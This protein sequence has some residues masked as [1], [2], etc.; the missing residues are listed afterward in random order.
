[1]TSNLFQFRGL[2]NYNFKQQTDCCGTYLLCLML[3]VALTSLLVPF[4]GL[5]SGR[6][7]HN[8][9]LTPRTPPPPPPLQ[10]ELRH[11]H[12]VSSSAHVIF[13]DVA[14]TFHSQSD[15]QGSTSHPYSLQPRSIKTFRP[16]SND[17]FTRVR[18]RSA[19]FAE[20][21]RLDWD[22]ADMLGP[23]V[24]KREV[25]LELAKMANN[26]YVDP[27]DPEWYDLDPKWNNVC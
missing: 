21:E 6:S 3:P 27:S 7:N 20:S 1:M 4:L 13:S 2:C 23:D 15:T 22:E 12:A 10:F 14:S 24:E 16:P 18:K 5:F 26:A 11:L 9:G 8:G 17:A 25:L 19:L